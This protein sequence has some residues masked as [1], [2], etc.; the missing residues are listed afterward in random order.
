M[1]KISVLN[2]KGEKVKD[3]KLNDNVW[4]IEPN[5]AVIYDAICFKKNE[6][7]LYD[8]KK[9][10]VEGYAGISSFKGKSSLTDIDIMTNTFDGVPDFLGKLKIYDPVYSL[11]IGYNTSGYVNKI[12]PVF[13]NV[14]LVKSI[15][16][17]VVY[18]KVRPTEVSRIFDE[19]FNEKGLFKLYMQDEYF[20]TSNL[21]YYLKEYARISLYIK[22][23]IE[24]DNTG[25]LLYY[26][27]KIKENLSKYHLYRELF[28]ASTDLKKIQK[29]KEKAEEHA[30]VDAEAEA[31]KVNPSNQSKEA[32][33]QSDFEAPKVKQLV[34][35]GF[36][37]KE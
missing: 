9:Y 16:K 36:E 31:V 24:G 10:T 6:K 7:D 23:G 30:H 13:G 20:K 28:R 34:F 4:S 14:E 15:E 17:N 22:R 2:V 32:F 11:F 12:S 33:I 37:S 27:S 25:D 18:D 3:I 26:E 29:K 8:F 35:P 1:P 21:S 5:D 19:L